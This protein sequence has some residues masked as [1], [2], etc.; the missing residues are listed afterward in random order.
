MRF[1]GFRKLRN[2]TGVI[3]ATAFLLIFFVAPSIILLYFS[4]LTIQQG[5]IVSGPTLESYV[6]LFSDPFS[7]FLFGRTI[8]LSVLVTIA[9]LVLGYPVAYIYTKVRSSALKAAILSVVAAPLLTSAL[10]LSF[11]WIVI[12][13]RRGFLNQALVSWGLLEEPLGILFTIQAVMIGLTQVMLPFMILPLVATIQSLPRDV[14]DAARDLGATRWQ[15]FWKVTLPQTFPGI[16]AGMT[17]VFILAYTAFTVPTLMGGGAIQIVSVFIWGSVRNLTWSTAAAYA[18]VL[19]LTSMLIIV[20]FNWLVRKLT[21][22]EAA[23][24]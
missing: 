14:E 4:L 7:Y 22:W 5:E 8:G 16:A 17:L 19:L 2:S 21:P 6:K 1:S 15:A 20:G 10:V 13:G 9:C 3:P 18:S 24:R 23:G 11:G 12:L